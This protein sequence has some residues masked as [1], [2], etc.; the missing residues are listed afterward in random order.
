MW[1]VIPNTDNL[2]FAN[3]QGQIKSADR[4]C[5]HRSKTTVTQYIR[6]GRILK[7]CL[8]CHGYYR[9]TLH[10]KDGTQISKSVHRLVA[11]AFI[12][13]PEGKPQINHKDGDKLNN[14]PSNLEWCTAS[15]NLQ[16][17]YNMGL[18]K[19]G[20]PWLGKR[21]K[22]HNRSLAVAMLD[23]EGNRIRTFD[24]LTEASLYVGVYPPHIS[25]VIKGKRKTCGGYKWELLDTK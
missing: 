5:L 13:N 22:H 6:K 12:P 15:E 17:A 14:N 23:K 25:S 20:K 19:G 9:V 2:Y 24:S 3:E 21:G 10:L 1:K 18:N 16:H 8:D 7:P 4:P 11:L